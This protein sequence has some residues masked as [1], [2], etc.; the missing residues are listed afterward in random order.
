MESAASI[1]L[2]ISS[3]VYPASGETAQSEGCV[4]A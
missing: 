2:P 3:P 1:S 4:I